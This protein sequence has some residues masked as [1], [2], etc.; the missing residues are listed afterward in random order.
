MSKPFENIPIQ[1][2]FEVCEKLGMHRNYSPRYKGSVRRCIAVS[3]LG[4]GYI[5]HVF[6]DTNSELQGCPLSVMLFNALMAVLSVVLE[7]TMG[8][9]SFVDVLDS[10][11][12][13]M[14]AT[15]Q[16]VNLK[17]TKTVGPTGGTDI[18]YD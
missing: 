5:G 18:V 2:T 1:I 15:G 16:A 12:E 17:K 9:E 7:P 13:F 4:G 6:K 11:E 14:K 10:I 8:N 3:D